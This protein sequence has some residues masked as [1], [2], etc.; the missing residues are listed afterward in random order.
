VA[1]VACALES[2][3]LRARRMLIERDHESFSVNFRKISI[4]NRYSSCS[5]TNHGICIGWW[6]D[7]RIIN[8]LRLNEYR[9]GRY[10]NE[11]W[12]L[13][14]LFCMFFCINRAVRKP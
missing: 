9:Q 10:L 5:W 6:I 14:F 1:V 8:E 4:T 13:V 2:L 7:E 12:N 3:E 11:K